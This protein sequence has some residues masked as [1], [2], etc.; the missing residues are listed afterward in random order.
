M[1]ARASA[2]DLD[3]P[4]VRTKEILADEQAADAK[5]KA[6]EECSW[7]CTREPEERPPRALIE[8]AICPTWPVVRCDAMNN[9]QPSIV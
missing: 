4:D 7:V 8:S 2:G 5:R 9:D 3:H 6:A 1:Y